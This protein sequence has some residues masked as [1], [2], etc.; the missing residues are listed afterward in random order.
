VLASAAERMPRWPRRRMRA[1]GLVG[2]A[3][4]VLPG[5]ATLAHDLN[6][7][8]R[9]AYDVGDYDRAI[10]LFIEVQAER[11]NDPA[12]SLNLARAL[13]EA[14]RFE[15]AILAARRLLNL[16]SPETQARGYASIGHAEFA[17]GRLPNSLEA[18]RR[19]LL[20]NPGD[21]NSRH[22]FEVV[23]RMLRPLEGASEQPPPDGN[24]PS[25][26]QP[27]PPPGGPSDPNKPGQPPGSPPGQGT[28]S[29][30]SQPGGETGAPSNDPARNP[31]AIDR[32]L[33]Q[34]DAQVN[35]LLLQAGEN[36]TAS[37]ALEILQL[38]AERNRIAA[39]RDGL[40]GGGNPGDY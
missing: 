10:N 7:D 13:Y 39:L 17:V 32:R 19:A 31:D 14:G 34:I 4:F 11:P 28:P 12:V 2:M 30:G 29:P 6:E 16:P 26:G 21:E 18:F 3:L 33:E 24:Q 35:A 20:E 1:I 40:A 9:R 27:T 36:P 38:L 23:L 15:E 25:N 5:C 37:E 8:A 22:D